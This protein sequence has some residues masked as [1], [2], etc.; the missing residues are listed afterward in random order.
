MRVILTSPSL[1]H[2]INGIDQQAVT[3]L[4]N[5]ATNDRVV[6]MISCHAKPDW[7]DVAF[8]GSNVQFVHRASRQ[9]GTA[10]GILANKIQVK[11]YE[12]LVLAATRD[13]LAM[14]K[15][16]GAMLIAAGWVPAA[17][18]DNF[19]VKVANATELDEVIRLV[20]GWVGNWWAEIDTPKYKVRA[21]ADLSS[22]NK[23]YDQVIFSNKV[24]ST[25]KK[26][27][28]HITALLT[29]CARSLLI[30]KIHLEKSLAFGVYPSSSSANDDTE[31]LSDFTHRLRTTVSRV[32]FAK[33]GAPLF[34]RHAPSKKRSSGQGANRLDPSNQIETIHLNP[35]YKTRVRGKHIIV[36]DDCTTYGASYAVAAAFLLKAGAASVTGVALGKFGNQLHYFDI[37]I[38][39]DPFAP[40]A[41]GQYT[42][43]APVFANCN[44]D[45]TAQALMRNLL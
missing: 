29:V 44:T 20:D 26:G 36:V 1:V 13:D 35:F 23:A 41:K 25:V 15:N 30:E 22:I 43:K 38:N 19:G 16:G 27:G 40:V 39:S 6:G 7:F 8:A 21:L 42:S 24:K 4:I 45:A 17:Q 9:D 28:A 2:N 14:A 10:I 11:P 32:Q 5:L 12:I 37:T 34:I 31:V 18:V 33:R 3:S